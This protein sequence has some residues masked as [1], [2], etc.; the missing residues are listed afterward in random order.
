M[1]IGT[2][3]GGL[4]EQGASVERDEVVDT[5][6]RRVID[7]HFD[8]SDWTEVRRGRDGLQEDGGSLATSVPFR[9]QLGNMEAPIDSVSKS[10][11]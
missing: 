11:G 10:Q 8:G 2:A 1:V 5:D 7:V 4:D 9:T 6:C 3:G